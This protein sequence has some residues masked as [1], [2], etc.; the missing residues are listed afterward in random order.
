MIKIFA[1]EKKR[2][3]ERKKVLSQ[4]ERKREREM[5]LH[6]LSHHG[7][8]FREIDSSVSISVDLIDHVAQLSLSGVLACT[9]HYHI[10]SWPSQ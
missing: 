2:K 3:K 7:E 5:N 9:S 6:L 8:E 1:S 10:E 4:K